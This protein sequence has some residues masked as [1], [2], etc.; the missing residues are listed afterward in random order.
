MIAKIFEF[1]RLSF[2]VY[3]D[4]I[5]MNDLSY[6]FDL[7][8]QTQIHIEDMLKRICNNNKLYAYATGK[9]SHTSS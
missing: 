5:A 8:S 1:P 3:G 2:M 9:T 4:D 7:H 6:Y